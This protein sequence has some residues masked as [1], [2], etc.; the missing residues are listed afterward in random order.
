LIYDRAREL[1][2]LHSVKAGFWTYSALYS[3][4]M[5]ALSKGVKWPGPEADDL[6]SRLKSG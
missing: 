1:S 2:P 3:L 6:H 5:G 4:D